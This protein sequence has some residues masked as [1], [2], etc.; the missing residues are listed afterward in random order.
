[1]FGQLN[2]GE[3]ESGGPANPYSNPRWLRQTWTDFYSPAFHAEKSLASRL[4]LST[5][6]P[7]STLF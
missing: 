7:K 2:K 5:M 3:Q 1:V 4:F 6:S